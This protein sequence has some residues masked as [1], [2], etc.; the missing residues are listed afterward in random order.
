MA[1]IDP[2]KEQGL[3]TDPKVILKINV[4]AH[5]DNEDRNMKWIWIEMLFII[6]EAK[7]NIL[8]FSK[9]SVTA[10]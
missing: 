3:E 2:N 9:G 7:E 6:E 5:L 4:I 1:E 10:L 8:G